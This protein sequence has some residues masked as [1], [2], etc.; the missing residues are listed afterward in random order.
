MSR[1]RTRRGNTVPPITA[2]QLPIIAPPTPTPTPTPKPDPTPTPV[3]TAAPTPVPTV[4]PTPAPTPKP[5]T[6][7]PATPKP[8]VKVTAKPTPKPTPAPATPVVT[9]AT[10]VP[11][12]PAP[13]PTP[14]S[15]AIVAAVPGAG[16]LGSASDPT[17]GAEVAGAIDQGPNSPGSGQGMAPATSLALVG[18]VGAAV[19]VLGGFA[20]FF[21]IVK[22]RRRRTE[23]PEVRG[24]PIKRPV[25]IPEPVMASVTAADLGF[26]GAAVA[27]MVDESLMPRW[28]R[29]SLQQVR[30]TDPIRATAE[31]APA[32]SFE[33][34]GLGP[35]DDYERR[36]IGYRL[37]RLL[38]SPDE[39]RANE[40]GT[41][42]QGDEVLLLEQRGTYWRVL[43]PDG[44]EGWVH[45][46]TLVDAPPPV[47]EQPEPMPEYGFEA[48]EIASVEEQSGDGI[49]EAYMRARGDVMVSIDEQET[50]YPDQYA[51][52]GAASDFEPAAE[53]VE[54]PAAASVEE[55]ELE[56]VAQSDEDEAGHELLEAYLK[57]HRDV[58]RPL[59][60]ASIDQVVEPSIDAAAVAA[61][62]VAPR[63]KTK[64]ATKSAKKSA[65]PVVEVAVEP[66]AEV[67]VEP[68]VE[69]DRRAGRA[70]DRSGHRTRSSDHDEAGG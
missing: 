40:V 67:A 32:L 26:A 47:A 33:T 27:P 9:E 8:V 69:T 23:K 18:L 65:E 29:P 38:D 2:A 56:P 6:P 55:A 45:R 3:P 58:I 28:R 22:R 13:T 34:A 51:A 57:A 35:I 12:T 24:A 5:A 4:A 39:L 53:L 15:S 41:L 14:V 19:L 42:D 48:E 54:E 60:A 43:C 50:V 1:L 70:R 21:L 20:F 52:T 68:A 61:A 11:P 36:R 30:K 25:L 10:P 63:T 7:K 31:A 62:A 46:M 16:S 59:E 37:V 66:T 44:R 64:R 49:L 17:P